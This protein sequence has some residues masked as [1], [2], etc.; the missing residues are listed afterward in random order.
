MNLELSTGDVAMYLNEVAA[1]DSFVDSWSEATRKKVISVYILMLHQ[2]GLLENGSS[3]LCKPDLDDSAWMYYI[4]L[5][6]AWFLEACFLPTYEIN[7]IK[8]RAI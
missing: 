7:D 6:E 4:R 8:E 5:G 1:Q 3:N 2:A